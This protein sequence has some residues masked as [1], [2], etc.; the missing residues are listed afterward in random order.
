MVTDQSRRARTRFSR[1][2]FREDGGLGVEGGVDGE[3]A[4]SNE[5]YQYNPQ[6]AVAGKP[7]TLPRFRGVIRRLAPVMPVKS[8]VHQS[9][10]IHQ[11][12]AE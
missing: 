3:S 11:V 7:D 9:L 1:E 8:S 6:S 2:V 10:V 5:S 4:Q 12:E